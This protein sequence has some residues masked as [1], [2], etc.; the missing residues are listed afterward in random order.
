M[1]SYTCTTCVCKANFEAIVVPKMS[2]VIDL[3]GS[4]VVDV[5]NMCGSNSESFVFRGKC[6][7]YQQTAVDSLR[8][9]FL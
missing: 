8:A 6:C 5:L 9:E 1:V 3:H 7:A 4:E 2:N